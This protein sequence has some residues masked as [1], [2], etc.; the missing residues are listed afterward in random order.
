[1]SGSCRPLLASDEICG[2]DMEE[3]AVRAGFTRL[4]VLHVG[5]LLL[6]DAAAMSLSLGVSQQWVHM[7]INMPQP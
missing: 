7:W 2:W 1:M 3:G 6:S 5:T 4:A